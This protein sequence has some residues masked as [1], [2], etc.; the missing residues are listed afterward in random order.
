MSAPGPLEPTR[1]KTRRWV[2]SERRTREC[3]GVVG[4]RLEEKHRKNSRLLL[5]VTPVQYRD[6]VEPRGAS[7][8]APWS[9]EKE[10]TTAMDSGA[11]GL[12]EDPPSERIQVGAAIHS[13]CVSDEGSGRWAPDVSL[14]AR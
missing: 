12:V 5:G 10:M 14:L 1:R 8:S 4:R 11:L 7:P 13:V 3:S 2:D 9:M 6:E